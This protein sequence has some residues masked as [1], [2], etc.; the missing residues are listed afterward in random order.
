KLNRVVFLD[1]TTGDGAAA[2]KRLANSDIPTEIALIL[3]E[4]NRHVRIEVP[5]RVMHRTIMRPGNIRERRRSWGGRR[6]RSSGWLRSRSRGSVRR[7]CF[8]CRRSRRRSFMLNG[9]GWCDCLC[10]LVPCNERPKSSC[11]PSNKTKREN[12]QQQ[13]QEEAPPL[14]LREFLRLRCKR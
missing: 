7:S 9:W 6:Y 10:P 12:D 8:S 3:I 14:A 1:K 5:R 2:L 4:R 13:W 11:K